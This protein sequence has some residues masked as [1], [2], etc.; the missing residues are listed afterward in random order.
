M[1]NADYASLI[2]SP[3]GARNINKHAPKIN[4]HFLR[5]NVTSPLHEAAVA[6]SIGHRP[7]SFA[8]SAVCFGYNR[9]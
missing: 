9:A 7:Q 2:P 1:K 3:S 4:Y 6:T 8:C 5:L